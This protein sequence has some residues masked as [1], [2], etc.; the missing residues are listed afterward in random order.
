MSEN[1]FVGSQCM[2]EYELTLNVSNNAENQRNVLLFK[3]NGAFHRAS[4][5][6][7]CVI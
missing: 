6:P 7:C 5:K 1:N 2:C 3:G 4:W